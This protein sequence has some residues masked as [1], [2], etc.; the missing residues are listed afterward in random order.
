[1]NKV[2]CKRCLLSTDV[3]G[4]RV[5]PGQICSVCEEYD[6]AWGDWD[7]KKVHKEVEFK[8]ILDCVK[9][10]KRSYDVL[11]P[12]SG[13]KDSSY[14]LYMCRKVFNLRCL[15][16]TFDNGFLSDHAKQNI[17][18]SC[19]HLGVDHIYFRLDRNFLMKLYRR[20]FLK[21][22]FFCPVCMRYMGVAI[23]RVQSAFGIPVSISGTSRRT[24]EHV[25]P[26]F[27]VDGDLNFI[28]NVL[29]EDGIDATEQLLIRPMGIIKSPPR[30]KMPDFLEWNYSEIY[31]K[32]STELEWKSPEESAEH[33]DCIVEPVVQYIRYR[34][35][36]SITP[37]LLRL[38]K[39]VTSGQITKAEAKDLVEAAKK[40][41]NHPPELQWFLDNIRI[42]EKDFEDVLT[43]PLKHLKYLKKNSAVKRR[44][45]AIKQSVLP[46]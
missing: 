2:T 43:S 44:I 7:Q 31:K 33:M 38:S 41:T 27:F 28:E 4:V 39:L 5:Q 23:G 8:K 12:L 10:K 32:I 22:G 13:G 16:V 46:F 6:Q 1:M 36:P 30:I 24:E 18:K 14:V 9:G 21:T 3:P 26:Q 19:Q 15:A 34:K 25:D 42:T 37:E 29:S 45:K 20:F 40:K 17:T 35:F 11:V